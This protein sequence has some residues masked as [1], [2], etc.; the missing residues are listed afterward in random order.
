MP[1]EAWQAI[2]E[3]HIEAEQRLGSVARRENFE[4]LSD[5]VSRCH[6][7][8]GIFEGGMSHGPAFQFVRLG[9]SLERADMSSRMID[10]AAAVLM[11]GH[12]GLRP[13]S[14]TVWR[15]V[16][17]ALSAYQMYRQYVRR[18]IS[19]PDVVRFLL[20]DTAFPRAIGYCVAQLEAAAAALPRHGR[21]LDQVAALKSRLAEI[22]V[23]QLDH[24]SLHRLV[25]DLQIEFAQLDRAIYVTWLDPDRPA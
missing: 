14:N 20:F 5:I 4:V 24:A 13:Y 3:M 18:R 2:N 25:D 21:T 6:E 17:R 10:V 16:L 11:S 7:I 15:S 23:E 12:D 9:R 19:P 22:D 8:T 1:S